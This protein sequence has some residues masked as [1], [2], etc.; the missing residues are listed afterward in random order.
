MTVAP[1]SW[2]QANINSQMDFTPLAN[3]GNLYREGQKRSALESL[4]KDL[5]AGNITYQQAAGRIGELGDVGSSLKF[6][7][8]AEARRKEDLANQASAGFGAQISG[9]FGGGEST[10]A[11]QPAPV[12]P[13]PQATASPRTAVEPIPDIVRTNP[14]GTVAGNVTAPSI[15][16]APGAMPPPGAPLVPGPLPMQPPPPQAAV[17]PPPPVPAD[18]AAAPFD[19]RFGNAQARAPG[20]EQGPTI[21]HVPM[22]I[23]ALRNQYLP[24]SD[25]K[26]AED[27]L[28]RAWDSAKP[29][30]K[31]QTLK[32]LQDDPSLKAIELELRRATSPNVNILP[33]EKAQ[34]VEMGKTLAE[35]HGGYLKEAL[36]VPANKA[37]L[38][39][40]ERA[41]TSKDFSSGLFQPVTMAAQRALVGLGIADAD[42]AAPNELFSKLQNKAIM[43]AGGSASGLGPQISNNDAKI[44]RD[45]TFNATNTPEGNRNIIGFQR[46]M[47]DRKVAYTKEMNKY[48][49]DHGGRIDINVMEHMAD[50]AERTPL[51]FTKIPGFKPPPDPASYRREIERRNKTRPPDQQIPLE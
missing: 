34:D 29:T 35:L 32:A 39:V 25:K 41:M 13:G 17:Q 24:A 9:A 27:M 2:P 22:L 20:L 3:L 8:L 4:G 31:I 11:R 6:L 19:A 5:A 45:S 21:E 12:A 44:I 37:T 26:I 28:K 36:K 30:E 10:P 47:E 7:E 43:D 40:A 38:D 16:A 23:N 50:W 33:G 46:L 14:D 15:P 48:A 18:Q 42:K 51:D 1:I 49:R